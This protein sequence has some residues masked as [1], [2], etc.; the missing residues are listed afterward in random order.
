MLNFLVGAANVL[1]IVTSLFLICLVLIQRGKGGGLAGAFG[2]VG[3]S[4]AFGTKAGD[5]FTRVTIYSAIF[6]FALALFL[7]YTSNSS[8]RT[9][10]GGAFG[11][12]R[13]DATADSTLTGTEA[14]KSSKASS[15]DA[16][17]SPVPAPP[18][19]TTEPKSPAQP[20]NPASEAINPT[21]SAPATPPANSPPK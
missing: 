10:R 12:G 16:T 7:V 5:V 17:T 21:S 13:S 3:G 11:A 15:G 14:D 19:T 1:M 20:L 8:D 18:A 4:S 2:G 9:G 6:W